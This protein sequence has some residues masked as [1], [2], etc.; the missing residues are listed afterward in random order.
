MRAVV[1]VVM[2]PSLQLLLRILH[3]D[4]LVGVQELIAQP[5]VE[6]LDHPVVGGL[7]R[8]RVLELD[9]TAVGPIVQ[10]FGGELRLVSP[11]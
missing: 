2:L 4:E 11:P 7:S 9:D 1:V 6:R 10:R 5:P 8:A 3:C